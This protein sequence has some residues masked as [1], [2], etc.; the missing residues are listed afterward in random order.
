MDAQTSILTDTLE[1]LWAFGVLGLGWLAFILLRNRIYASKYHD[2][3]RHLSYA[4]VIFI[5]NEF[6]RIRDFAKRAN[7]PAWFRFVW[8]RDIAVIVFCTLVVIFTVFIMEWGVKFYTGGLVE[9]PQGGLVFKTKAIAPIVG[10]M[11]G[12]CL[13]I[14]VVSALSARSH[15]Y[16]KFAQ[17]LASMSR[18]R[19]TVHIEHFYRARLINHEW[20]TRESD[21]LVMI[22]ERYNEA[23]WWALRLTAGLTVLVF[24]FDIWRGL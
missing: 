12:I 4:E 7:Y 9:M 17:Y 10:T 6:T 16:E 13:G 1:G 8:L 22:H 18:R 24:A 5:D 21:L 23:L 11:F 14:H 19:S 2:Y 3:D 15:Q 20:L